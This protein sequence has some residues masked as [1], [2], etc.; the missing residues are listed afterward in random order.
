LLP[1]SLLIKTG[2]APLSFPKKPL[3]EATNKMYAQL[4]SYLRRQ[5][6]TV[7]FNRKDFF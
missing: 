1:S 4:R 5:S 2:L 7:R 6:L 3:N